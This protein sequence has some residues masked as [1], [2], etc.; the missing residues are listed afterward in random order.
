MGRLLSKGF[1]LDQIYCTARDLFLSDP[2]AASLIALRDLAINGHKEAQLVVDILERDGNVVDPVNPNLQ[3][4]FLLEPNCSCALCF[5]AVLMGDGDPRHRGLLERSAHMGYPYALTELGILAFEENSAS[6][7]CQ[8]FIRAAEAGDANGQFHLSCCYQ[9]GEAVEGNYLKVLYWA[10]KSALGGSTNGMIQWGHLCK[11]N[12][13]ILKA[14]YWYGRCAAMGKW[15]QHIASFA[16]ATVSEYKERRSPYLV[17][18]VY[19]L[20]KAIA[21]DVLDTY[22]F[23]CL[24]NDEQ[25]IMTN[26]V[27][28]F[29]QWRDRAQK[30]TLTWLCIARYCLKMHLYYEN[31][32]SV[33]V[34][35]EKSIALLIAK[36]VWNS[37]DDAGNCFS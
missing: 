10:E 3:E 14:I 13:D 2:S 5:A 23:T 19:A 7:A 8:W 12:D 6:M 1:S 25:C 21:L 30:A 33:E 18:I 37:R 36:I 34:P 35:F 29:S 17:N 9:N 22:V 27:V 32:H 11:D 31:G 16:V 20:G 28:L 26:V 24:S 15:I 4:L